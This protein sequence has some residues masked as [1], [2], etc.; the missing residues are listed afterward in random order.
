MKKEHARK[1]NERVKEMEDQIDDM[2]RTHQRENKELGLKH[3]QILED[4]DKR[5]E[6][7]RVALESERKT[8]EKLH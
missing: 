3:K 2:K 8:E 6:S 7:L 4:K 1:F 5:N